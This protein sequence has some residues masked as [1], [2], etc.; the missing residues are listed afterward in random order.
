MPHGAHTFKDHQDQNSGIAKLCESGV[1]DMVYKV[2]GQ[3]RALGGGSSYPKDST[4][5]SLPRL[6]V[7]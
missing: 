5:L 2:R 7:V 4:E 1:Q 6:P 3:H